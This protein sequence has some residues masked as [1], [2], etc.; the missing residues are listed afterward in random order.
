MAINPIQ[1][2]A[3]KK[4]NIISAASDMPF[5]L[6]NSINGKS[7]YHKNYT[8]NADEIS[9]F[10]DLY[11][12]D[13]LENLSSF[14]KNELSNNNFNIKHGEIIRGNNT[15][16]WID[17]CYK[18]VSEIRW[19]K[20]LYKNSD[21]LIN[22]GFDPTNTTITSKLTYALYLDAFVYLS[23]SIYTSAIV[24]KNNLSETG[25]QKCG[26]GNSSQ[27]NFLSNDKLSSFVSVNKSNFK[28]GTLIQASDI[29][30]T[31]LNYNS[32]LDL[33][34]KAKDLSCEFC[35][36]KYTYNYFYGDSGDNLKNAVNV[37]FILFSN[38]NNFQHVYDVFNFTG[39]Y[40]NIS[41]NGKIILN[42]IESWKR[43]ANKQYNGSNTVGQSNWDKHK[44][45]S[46]FTFSLDDLGIIGINVD[47]TFNGWHIIRT[48][49]DKT[50]LSDATSLFNSTDK[51]KHVYFKYSNKKNFNSIKNV[52]IG[53]NLSQPNSRYWIIPD[54]SVTVLKPII[55]SLNGKEITNTQGLPES[56][57]G[58]LL[59]A[60]ETIDEGETRKTYIVFGYGKTNHVGNS[61]SD[62]SSSNDLLENINYYGIT[63]KLSAVNENY[64]DTNGMLRYD[65]STNK[66]W[67]ALTS[68]D[69]LNK[70]MRDTSHE[71]IPMSAFITII[72]GT[73][74]WA[75]NGDMLEDKNLSLTAS[76]HQRNDTTQSASI[77]D[78][79]KYNQDVDQ[80]ENM[81][82]HMKASLYNRNAS[83]SRYIT[84]NYSGDTGDV[85]KD[86]E[87]FI[88]NAIF[89]S[90]KLITLKRL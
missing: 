64:R 83:I 28:V 33:D 57:Y 17:T 59:S 71:T 82:S 13:T 54:I 56:Q 3:V 65:N 61:L 9:S 40:N 49:K 52:P 44:L 73:N 89:R 21:Y 76:I 1:N 6:E 86:G 32:I 69:E 60:V 27:I 72:F 23:P 12:N 81:R 22:I 53:V 78:S 24:K 39:N 47:F 58:K 5:L 67:K 46:N 75:R 88:G 31:I 90:T 85:N 38:K 74:I 30:N 2:T 77:N 62:A 80:N 4:G 55:K 15:F 26:G 8:L 37:K 45:F 84:F 48:D 20:F 51:T 18:K 70:Q 50:E 42:D 43:L 63:R 11:N 35:D 29:N 16:N 10:S 25:W 19:C 66:F 36:G 79:I 14:L 7:I 34:K 68:I 87:Y 41:D